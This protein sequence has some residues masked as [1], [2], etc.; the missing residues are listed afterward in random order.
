ML[1]DLWKRNGVLLTGEIGD[2]ED[3]VDY[4]PKNLQDVEIPDKNEWF[5]PADVIFKGGIEIFSKWIV[6]QKSDIKPEYH[7]PDNYISGSGLLEW[8]IENPDK[9][10]HKYREKGSDWF[11][12]IGP[13]LSETFDKPYQMIIKGS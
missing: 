12:S 8:L 3:V 1:R 2:I 6:E 13:Y 7:R 5:L 4:I 9:I 10:E 11:K